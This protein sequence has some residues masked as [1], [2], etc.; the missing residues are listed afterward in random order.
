MFTQQEFY[1]KKLTTVLACLIVSS[2]A[3]AATSTM[4]S[5]FEK[6]PDVLLASNDR[7][8]SYAAFDSK[9][10]VNVREFHDMGQS[11]VQQID[12]VVNC[13]KQT[14]AMAG[15]QVL[16]GHDIASVGFIAPQT[17]QLSF[18]K[19]VIDHDLK[20]ASNVC[21]KQVAMNNS[22]ATNN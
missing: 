13:S 21:E 11:G 6:D 1:M 9:A 15:F 4:P 19:P 18:Y 2:F 10:L 22:G 12:Y 7:T 5:H 16:K 8:W 3:S 14:M 17:Q 20:I